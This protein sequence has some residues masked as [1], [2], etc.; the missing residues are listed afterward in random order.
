M[1]DGTRE[2]EGL[3]PRSS[4][5]PYNP[6]AWI[7][8]VLIFWTALCTL[9]DLS[10]PKP[11]IGIVFTV[12]T[13]APTIFSAGKSILNGARR[14]S[15]ESQ[16]YDAAKTART[17]AR[18]ASIIAAVWIVT[19]IARAVLGQ[20]PYTFRLSRDVP[21]GQVLCIVIFLALRHAFDE[22]ARKRRA[23][24]ALPT[25]DEEGRA[26]HSASANTETAA[27][28]NDGEAN[29]LMYHPSGALLAL[30]IVLC[31]VSFISEGILIPFVDFALSRVLQATVPTI[32]FHLYML[33]RPDSE[34]ELQS[35]FVGDANFTLELTAI[36][37]A[38]RLLPFFSGGF[39][40]G[41]LEVVVL[42]YMSVR[43]TLSLWKKLPRYEQGS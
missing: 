30:S 20:W 26:T 25:E 35:H 1:M 27:A 32:I 39:V 28:S 5:A 12:T 33:V 14:A 24:I 2:R 8:G 18:R 43:Y 13:Y 36:W 3:L 11:W 41:L 7:S 6:S 38:T 29:T 21:E 17:R 16:D 4:D 19:S 23:G 9:R 37:F 10:V 31:T 40:P 15:T 22:R 42:S 34:L